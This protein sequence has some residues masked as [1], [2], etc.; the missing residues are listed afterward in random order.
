MRSV[1]S[2]IAGGGCAKRTTGTRY[3]FD[4]TKLDRRVLDEF[5]SYTFNGWS[6]AE[7]VGLICIIGE[8][9]MFAK[10]QGCMVDSRTGVV[11]PL[12]DGLARESAID[13]E[14][15]LCTKPMLSSVGVITRDNLTCD[16]CASWADDGPTSVDDPLIDSSVRFTDACKEHLELRQKYILR[17][18]A[19][20]NRKLLKHE[21]RKDAQGLRPAR[22]RG[23]KS[24]G[25]G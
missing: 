20:N 11:V 16:Q 18:I 2:L 9:D 4:V 17:I 1:K 19:S 5:D 6:R 24:A 10:G 14:C 15:A 7:L 8:R 22:R 21:G 13:W 23:D 25:A 3:G 12:D